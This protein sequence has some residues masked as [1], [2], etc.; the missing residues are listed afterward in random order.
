M[1]CVSCMVIP[2]LIWIWFQFIMP[3]LKKIKSLFCSTS[4]NNTEQKQDTTNDSLP[5]CPFKFSQTKDET[6]TTTKT[7]ENDL[8]N[9]DTK[10]VN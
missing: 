4:C 5:K 3:I 8:S 9:S 1:V 7:E 2:V 10:K 6:S